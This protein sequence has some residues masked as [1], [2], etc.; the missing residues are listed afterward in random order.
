MRLEGWESKLEELLNAARV[1]PYRLGSHDCF[2]LAVAVVEALTGEKGLQ[3]RYSTPEEAKALIKRH[4]ATFEDAFD[5]CFR[6]PRIPCQQAQR[7]DLLA[8]K[9]DDEKHLAICLGTHM[10][11]LGEEGL[12]FLPSSLAH[13]A[14][15]VQCLSR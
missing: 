3:F 7:G 13:C 14:W 6:M 11:C 9:L 8:V 5:W 12:V 2:T 15:R 10:A 1:M 4:G